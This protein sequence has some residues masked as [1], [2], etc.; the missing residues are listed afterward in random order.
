VAAKRL[1]LEFPGHDGS[2]LAGLYEAPSGDI[3]AYALFAH[4]FTCGKDIAAASRISRALVAR[5]FA[6]LRFDFT[7]LGGSD[8]D[9]AN[10]NFSS[11]IQDLIAAAN[12][13]RESYQAP[14]LLIGHSLGGTAVLNA[15]GQID[16]CKGVATIG[17]PA[18]AAHV[19]KL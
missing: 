18:D 10:T 12:F 16:E 7:G 8:G 11:N 14:A 15:A 1:K 4:C 3:Q 6:V 5:G 19:A 9:F 17:A 13:M 2:N